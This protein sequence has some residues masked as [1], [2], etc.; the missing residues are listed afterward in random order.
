MKVDIKRILVPTDFSDTSNYAVEKAC[1]MASKM[2]AKLYIIHVLESSPYKL[3]ISDEN[4]KEKVVYQKNIM[5]RLGKTAKDITEK[6][7]IEVDTLIGEA[8][9][10]DVIEEAVKDN[11][12]DLIIMGTSGASGM[13]E[14]LIGSNAQRVVFRA[15]CPV[16]TFKVPPGEMGF[17]TIVLPVESWNS[18]IEKLDYVTTIAKTYNSQVHLLGIIE[19]RKKPDMRQVLVLLEAAEKYLQENNIS[20]VRKIIASDQ[21]AKE[22]LVY[23]EE[24]KANL[25]M[26]MTEHES[27]LQSVL[28]GLLAKQI[29]NHSEIPVM[30]IKPAMYHTEKVSIKQGP[31]RHRK[32]HSNINK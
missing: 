5:D 22:T 13:R 15:A 7:Q 31:L 32:E 2:D 1:R 28:P 16:I 19:N 25:I 18:S 24:I 17:K 23:A 4:P 12:I 20:F 14:F 26:V 29:A 27:K 8:K 10:A 9:V 6:Y 3:V 21:V 11:K 30:S